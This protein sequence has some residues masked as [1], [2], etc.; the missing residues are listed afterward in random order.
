MQTDVKDATNAIKGAIKYG[1]LP[2]NE[3]LATGV[4]KYTL[5]NDHI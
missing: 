2:T 1:Y 3:E 4:Y 5:S